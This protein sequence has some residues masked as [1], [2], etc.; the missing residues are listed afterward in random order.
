M[1][2]SSTNHLRSL[3]DD[4]KHK[5]T[6]PFSLDVVSLYTSIPPQDAIQATLSFIQK[7]H[8]NTHGL[9]L[10][11]IQELLTIITQNTYFQFEG[12]I[13][14]QISG[15]P[16]GSS[17]SAI[18]AIIYMDYVEQQTIHNLNI[19]IYKRYVDDTLILT[20]NKHEADHI[21][22][23]MNSINRHIQFEIEHPTSDN[24]LNLLDFSITIDPTTHQQTFNF[25]KK[26]AKK[27]LFVNFKSALPTQSKINFIQNDISRITNRCSNNNDRQSHLDNFSK[28]LHQNDYPLEFIREHC[29]PKTKRNTPRHTQQQHTFYFEMPFINDATDKKIKRIFKQNNIN[30]RLYRKSITLRQQLRKN[31]VIKC[32]K[33]NCPINT[34]KICHKRLCIYTA[35]CNRC[36]HFYIGSTI[37]TLHT[38]ATEHLS[39]QHSSIYQHKTSCQSTFHFKIIDTARDIVKLRFLEAIHIKNRQPQI[40]SKDEANELS[41]LIFN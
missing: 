37:R 13:Y 24:T 5:Y 3:P 31:T 21:L 14:Q 23:N 18:L 22:H 32:S 2:N 10:E 40:N 1:N 7:H 36:N 33:P 17:T 16:M 12:H 26:T 8:T 30:V 4:I 19:G 15:L 41:H 29:R 20:L 6:Y 9:T 25:Y 27:D 38:R 35:T 34:P 11:H 28:I 39:N